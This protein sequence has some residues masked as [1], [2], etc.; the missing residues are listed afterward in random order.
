MEASMPGS[1]DRSHET[2]G[3]NFYQRWGSGFIALPVLLV[4]ALIGLAV[5]QPGKT[6]WI[7]DEVMAEFAGTNYGPQ[8]APAQV[9]KAAR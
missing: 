9:A 4:I 8:A 7:A 5:I 1:S 2:T 3:N 6:N